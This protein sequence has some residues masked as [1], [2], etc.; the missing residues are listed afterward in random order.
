MPSIAF[1]V[2]APAMR[3]SLG[4]QTLSSRAEARISSRSPASSVATV[5]VTPSTSTVS[6]TSRC[7]TRRPR[8]RPQRPAT[9]TA[10]SGSSS[11]EFSSHGYRAQ[12]SVTD[13]RATD[14]ARSPGLPEAAAVGT[15]HRLRI[16]GNDVAARL[17]RRAAVP[18]IGGDVDRDA[19][20]VLGAPLPARAGGCAVR[21]GGV[22]RDGKLGLARR[23][24]PDWSRLRSRRRRA[25][26]RPR[27]P[28]R[29]S[30]YG[31]AG[32]PR[33]GRGPRPARSRRRRP[34]AA[35]GPP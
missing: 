26:R 6:S 1:S 19:A 8:A 13:D 30:G 23:R 34:P 18:P 20:P 28:P 4:G 21:R 22:V 2:A 35:P 31:A 9:R 11:G 10:R 32:S 12:T 16:A 17:D 14:P 3:R 27:R 7:R 29:H 24:R 5:T 33:P 25:P 15:D